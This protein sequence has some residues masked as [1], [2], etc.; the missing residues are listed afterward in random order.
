MSCPLQCPYLQDARKYEKTPARGIE[1]MP[2][3]DIRVPE[4][5]LDENRELLE[6]LSRALVTAALGTPGAVDG[7]LRDALAA[8]IRTQ[9]TLQSGIYYESLPD[10]PLAAKI[11]RAVA[12]RA[13]EFRQRETSRLGLTTTR[14][15]DL[16]GLL[17]FFERMAL[18]SDNGRPRGRAFVD[19][20]RS[21]QPEPPLEHS[22]GSP[23][24][25]PG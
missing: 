21:L 11:F 7:D 23:L 3:R 1:Q 10:N 15:T 20:L 19:L 6:E 22:G 18:N 24:V 16:L 12:E 5:L 14:D 25:L 2:N 8:L 9:R 17:V 4:E 13:S